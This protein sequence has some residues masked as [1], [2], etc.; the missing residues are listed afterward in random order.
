M[1]SKSKCLKGFIDWVYDIHSRNLYHQENTK[2]WILAWFID[3]TLMKTTI[4][5]CTFYYCTQSY[6]DCSISDYRN[7][8]N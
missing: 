2:K 7:I 5:I 3:R 8:E 4:Y 1:T 6:F